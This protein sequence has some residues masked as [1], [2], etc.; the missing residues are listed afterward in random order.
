MTEIILCKEAAQYSDGGL[1]IKG[2]R[3]RWV[4]CPLGIKDEEYAGRVPIEKCKSNVCGNY[5][6][7]AESNIET[8][9]KKGLLSSGS[10][11]K[12]SSRSRRLRIRKG[13][14]LEDITGRYRRPEEITKDKEYGPETDIMLEEDG[15]RVLTIGLPS[16]PTEIVYKG[17]EIKMSGPGYKNYT[18]Q[19]DEE[20]SDRIDE[21]DPIKRI[22]FHHGISDVLLR[23]IKKRET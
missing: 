4:T 22:S 21:R 19:I 8:I 3:F 2:K 15:V 12:Y 20:L 9:R 11:G 6:G 14:V 18:V 10:S 17:G 5:L 13:R 1:H 23:L 7:T 16:E